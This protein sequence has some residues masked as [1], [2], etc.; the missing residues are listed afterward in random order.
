MSNWTVLVKLYR[1][2]LKHSWKCFGNFWVCYLWKLSAFQNKLE[3]VWF[4]CLREGK[5]IPA[6]TGGKVSLLCLIR[7][8]FSSKGSLNLTSIIKLQMFASN[9][10][11]MMFL[12]H[13][14]S[15]PEA[16]EAQKCSPS[17]PPSWVCQLSL[18]ILQTCKTQKELIV[19]LLLSIKRNTPPSIIHCSRALLLHSICRLLVLQ[20]QSVIAKTCNLDRAC[21]SSP[22]KPK[23][24]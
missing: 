10:L 20:L 12:C 15:F 14:L 9:D 2:V 4:L 16:I 19:L 5:R 24:I 1:K 6:C 17:V 8:R 3:K 21:E 23:R 7:I 22:V 13:F 18:Q 11:K